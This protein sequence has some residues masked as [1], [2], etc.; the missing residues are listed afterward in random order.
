MVNIG[1]AAE[2]R[3]AYNSVIDNAKVYNPNADIHGV[4]IQEMAPWGTEVILGSIYTPTFGPT[5]M[6]GL[7]GIFVEIL[8]DVTFRVAPVPRELALNMLNEIKGGS[9]LQGA[10]GEKPRDLEVLAD[11]ISR[12]SQLIYDLGDEIHESDANPVMVYAESE[13]VK[14]VDARLILRRDGVANGIPQNSQ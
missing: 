13:G 8:K 11:V 2:V 7:G 1:S 14:I 3:T 4:A 9:I 12:F 6:F 10:R 5:I